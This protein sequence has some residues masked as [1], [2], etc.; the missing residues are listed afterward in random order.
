[1]ISWVDQRFGAWGV[2]LQNNRGQGSR[3]L[4]A[5]W[6]SVGGGGVAQSFVPIHSLECSRLDDW[7]KSLPDADKK[8]L[9][10]VYCAQRTAIEHAYVLKMSTRTLYARLHA[11][12]TSYANHCD[13]RRQA[14]KNARKTNC[15]Q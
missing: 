13:D 2:W 5:A 15:V 10:E 1:M 11:L 3:G 6:G 4:T 9:A 7:V 8:I 14:Q 12:Q